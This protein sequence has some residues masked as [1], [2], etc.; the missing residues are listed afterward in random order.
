MGDC[1]PT[2][3]AELATMRAD[4]ADLVRSG[5]GWSLRELFSTPDC[6]IVDY[7]KGFR[8]NRF[9]GQALANAEAF[10]RRHGIWLEAGGA[11]Y[12]SMTPYLHPNAISAE[13]MT[14]IGIYNAILFWLNDTVGREKFAALSLDRQLRAKATVNSL[15][16]LLETRCAAPEPAPVEAAT[17]EFI[18]LLAERADARWLDDFLESTAEHLRPAIRDQNAEARGELLSVADYIDL[19]A[20]VSGMYPAIALCEFGRDEYLLWDRIRAA[21]L[22]DD[23]R[24]LR[25]LTVD[26][27]ALMNDVFSFEKECIVDNADFNLIPV[28]LLDVP[29]ATLVDAVQHAAAIVRDLVTEFRAVCVRLELTCRAVDDRPLVAT[30][31]GHVADLVGSVQAT[32][33]WQIA[34]HRYKGESIFA[35]NRLW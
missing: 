19:R 4:H 20:H 21:G 16:R 34:T 28:C 12:N 9:G 6:D 15:C 17:A 27:G 25:R 26:I 11:H 2:I 7:C 1:T 23:V 32:W 5:S 30:L 10:S 22:E 29:G 33:E 35:E 31:S 14:I 3:E 24:R 8:P 13:R 18:A